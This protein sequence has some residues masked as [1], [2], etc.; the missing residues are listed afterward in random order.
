MTKNPKGAT[1]SRS[2]KTRRQAKPRRPGSLK[3][4]TADLIDAVGGFERAA[5]LSGVSRSRLFGYTDDGEDNAARY[6]NAA[7]VRALEAAADFPH[8]TGY[9]AAE[10]GYAMLPCGFD[11]ADGVIAAEV[12]R[13]A[14][15][16]S[17]VFGGMAEAL[18]DGL[19]DAAEAR[20]E[21]ENLD[22][23]VADIMGLRA[24]LAA[25]RD[26]EGEQ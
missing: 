19:V 24:H 26:G 16:V 13:I 8:V 5:D 20:R 11:P 21:I 25:V 15:D 1:A 12:A 23:T 6:I 17:R 22:R 4:A 3:K 10:R 9:L 2:T 7:A 18:A 14:E